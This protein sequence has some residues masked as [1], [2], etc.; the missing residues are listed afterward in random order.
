[1]VSQIDKFNAR[2]K[3]TEAMADERK[4]RKEEQE[5]KAPKEPKAENK[6]KQET[7][8]KPAPKPDKRNKKR[9]KKMSDTTDWNEQ[10][11]N[12]D[13]YKLAEKLGIDLSSFTADS[14]DTKK[15][16]LEEIKKKIKETENFP[17]NVTLT[18]EEKKLF[19]DIKNERNEQP[20]KQETKS[21]EVNGE[22]KPSEGI[23]WIKQKREL[24]EKFAHDENLVLKNDPAKDNEEKSFTFSL[25]K[26]GKNL[27]EMKYTSPT[28]VHISKAAELPMY[29]G[30]V[31]DALES[32]LSISFGKSLNDKQKA[33]LLATVLMSEKKTYANGDKI[34]LKNTTTIDINAEYFKT[35]PQDVQTVL[36]E[37]VDNQTQKKHE[38]N[39]K[40][41]LNKKV[42]AL[43][44]K[45]RAK[46]V[47]DG[48]KN[49]EL[50]R[51]EYRTAMHEGMTDEDKKARQDKLEERERTLAA[52]LGF[53]PD[54]ETTGKDGK[55]IKVEKSQ[56][57][58]DLLEKNNPELVKSLYNKYGKGR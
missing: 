42:K 19:N 8:P 40:K 46:A 17:E 5:D 29:Q 52:H 32:N 41:L 6:T 23:E 51:E 3:K 15:T 53:I 45:I 47:A 56:K 18:P 49:S 37:Y 43:R 12:D 44:D 39:D 31:K 58:K 28:A 35:L 27:G 7:E 34:E 50:S 38:N 22:E 26:D 13:T 9:N 11:K 24:Y 48:K 33:L 4:K 55:K 16:Q 57:T 20:E 30:I 36:N 21:L 2:K 14:E 54:Y 1:M 10:L 25:E